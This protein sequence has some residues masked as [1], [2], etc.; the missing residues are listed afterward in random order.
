MASLFHFLHTPA[1]L[2][3]GCLFWISAS[4]ASE[5]SDCSS[6]DPAKAVQG[7]SAILK[8]GSATPPKQRAVAL[9][10]RGIA[11]YDRGDLDK[12]RADYTAAIQ[13]D[14]TNADAFHNRADLMLRNGALE[15]AIAD[16]SQAVGLNGKFSSAYN[17]RG[18][19][20]RERGQV[21]E[22]I[23]DFNKAIELDPKSP[24]AY[25]G[26]ANALRDKGESEKAIKDYAQ[27][28][29]IDPKYATAYIG[30]ANAYS[31]QSN[32][33]AALAD[34]DAA[35]A[36]DSRDPTGFNNR[37]TAYQNKGELDKA[38]ADYSQAI[39]LD[40]KR[41]AFYFNRALAYH[42][43]EDLDRAAADYSSAIRI[44]SNYA[45]AYH[46]RGLILQRKGDL[47]RAIADFSKAIEINPQYAQNYSSRGIALLRKGDA[48]KAIVD[49]QKSAGLDNRQPA[50]MVG[51]GEAYA[52]LQ[53]Y[54][55]ARASLD[56]A[57][58]LDPL[59]SEAYLQRG[60]LMET[61]G[62]NAQ[63]SK[64]Y[65]TALSFD[66]ELKGAQEAL[67]KASERIKAA[68]V[69]P[70]VVP[71][72]GRLNRVALVIG[73][74]D[75]VRVQGLPNAIHD[76][77]LVAETFQKI[78]FRQVITV[79]NQNREG[80][81]VALRKFRDLADSA[82]WA[83]IYYAGHGIEIDGTN[84]VVPTDARLLT[85]RDVPDEA[86]SLGRFLDAID[87]AKEMKLVILDACRENPFLNT[88]KMSSAS[89]TIGRGLARVEPDG[90]TLVAY[91]AKHGQIAMDGKGSNSPFASA[92]VNRML[93]P[94]IEIRKLFGLVR[95]D[96]LSATDRKQE[97]FI[98]GT[99]G[100]EDHFLNPRN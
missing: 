40:S 99:L 29:S 8:N 3:L 71:T 41:A 53:M 4:S 96:V 88:M 58:E 100:G 64:D 48:R 60:R 62:D 42:L 33:A 69:E 36:I 55:E 67:K 7:C 34:Y 26:R 28:I 32:W 82:E 45:F 30:R 68:K 79:E 57:L 23:A 80:L 75:Y 11:F 51:L 89:R 44:D 85:D 13:L 76:A 77:K 78:G 18:N 87:R 61:M 66:P 56:K 46:N 63:A 73:N 25:N 35:I 37:G 10:N 72:T 16:Y 70:S 49:L 91:S 43:K 22:A 39:A 1:I 65:S 21:D 59:S 17:G 47:D 19:A 93:T 24:F 90:G 38:I 81:L 83:V 97:P 2:F 95:D 12:A 15:A 86:I 94:E 74:G 27:A 6:G 20:L 9:V 54:R 52:K 5:W 92:L 50:V 98:Y 14:P 84:Y 31:D